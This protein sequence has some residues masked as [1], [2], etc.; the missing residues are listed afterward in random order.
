MVPPSAVEEMDLSQACRGHSGAGQ[1]LDVIFVTAKLGQFL[2]NRFSHPPQELVQFVG[3]YRRWF[4]HLGLV[5]RP[6]SDQ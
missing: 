1:A 6:R 3:A 4:L 5:A 2:E